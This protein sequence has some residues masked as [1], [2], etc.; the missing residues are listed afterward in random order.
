M[1]I[2]IARAAG[3]KRGYE[4][5]V[6]RLG[7]MSQMDVVPIVCHLLGIDPPAHAQGTVPRDYL[8]GVD[9][10]FVRST[11]LPDWE[12]GTDVHGYGDR[13]WTQGGDMVAGFFAGESAGDDD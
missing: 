3:L 10:E 11:E 1:A 9:A 4:R 2:F 8:E 7:Y 13:V 6:N 5:P 12:D